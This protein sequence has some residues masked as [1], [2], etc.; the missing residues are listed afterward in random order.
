MYHLIT[1]S[2][3]YAQEVVKRKS[4]TM[5]ILFGTT[6]IPATAAIRPSTVWRS[7]SCLTVYEVSHQ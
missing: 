2:F 1:G 3:Q 6:S 5:E 4:L 7:T